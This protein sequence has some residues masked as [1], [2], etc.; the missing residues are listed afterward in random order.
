M[1]SIC[2][3]VYFSQTNLSFSDSFI[4]FLFLRVILPLLSLLLIA[5]SSSVL[6]TLLFLGAELLAY[7][8]VSCLNHSK[9]SLDMPLYVSSHH[10]IP[11]SSFSVTERWHTHL[12]LP[13]SPFSF[14]PIPV[15]HPSVFVPRLILTL[16]LV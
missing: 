14:S 12:S 3:F 13:T 7:W 2:L 4:F 10:I 16:A 5:L 1:L 11:F 6:S 15:C 8:A 9:N